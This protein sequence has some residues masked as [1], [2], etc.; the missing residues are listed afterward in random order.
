MSH[1]AVAGASQ[2]SPGDS[3]S[4]V[5]RA[6]YGGSASSVSFNRFAACAAPTVGGSRNESLAAVSGRSTLPPS[7]GDGSPAAPVIE[8]AGRHV[9]ASSAAS[10]SS[11]M[12]RMPGTNG[13]SARRLA[14]MPETARACSMRSRGMSAWRSRSRISPV[15]SSSTRESSALSIRNEEGTMP[16]AAPEC[17]PSVSTSTVST[18]LTTPRSEVVVHRCS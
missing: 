2:P 17:T 8:S 10:G 15:R 16:L 6:P 12:G 3:A 1:G 18:P 14:S 13:N 9:P 11:C 5:T 7:V 4:N